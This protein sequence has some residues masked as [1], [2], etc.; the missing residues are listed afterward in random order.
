MKNKTLLTRAFSD[1]VAKLLLKEDVFSSKNNNW[2]LI[3]FIAAFTVIYGHSFGM[4]NRVRS[5]DWTISHIALG[6]TYSGQMAVIVFFFLSGA[7]VTKSLVTSRNAFEYIAKRI[8]RLMPGLG[9]CL[10]ISGLVISPILGNNPSLRNIFNYINGNI[11]L[12]TNNF[13]I[14]GVFSNHR[15]KAING[16]LWTLPNEMRLYFVLF[17]F[18]LIFAKVT[19]E[20]IVGLLLVLLFFL[21][22]SPETT[23]LIGS[24][25]ALMGNGLF[26]INSMFFVLG[27]IIWSMQLGRIR[28]EIYLFISILLYTYFRFHPERQY[29]I[30]LSL[31]TF[32]M[33]VANFKPLFIFAPKHDYSYGIYLYGWISGQIV[34][35]LYPRLNWSLS[36]F[37]NML[38]S[39]LFAAISWH[40]VE[41]P[42]LN[43]VKD[44]LAR[45]NQ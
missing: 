31:V 30:F 26:V 18:G 10:L 7:L 3:R 45:I 19:R 17:I 8:S 43:F 14:E 35:S 20:K 36:L 15:F 22:F 33:F 24:N 4:F 9:L 37:L 1:L 29:F 39:L 32:S 6:S 2:G 23:P 16:S 27:G 21:Y 34:V 44:R 38:L 42:S 25:I 13:Y 5:N 28:G 40:L 11:W 12:I 41:K